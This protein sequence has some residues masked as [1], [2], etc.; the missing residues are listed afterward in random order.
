MIDGPRHTSGSCSPA[1]LRTASMHRPPLRILQS[2]PGSRTDTAAQPSSYPRPASGWRSVGTTLRSSRRTPIARAFSTFR[3]GV[4]SIGPERPRRSIRSR[5]RGGTSHPGR[6]SWTFCVAY[7]RS[8][9]STFTL[10]TASMAWRSGGGPGSGGSLHH[11]GARQPR[12]VD[13]HQKQRAKDLYH[14]FIEDPIIHGASAMLCTSRREELSFRDLGYTVPTWVIPIGID[15]DA[16][17]CARSPPLRRCDR[18]WCRCPRH[19]FL[20]RISAKKG[21]LLLVESFRSIAAAFPRAHLVIAGPDDEGIGRGLVSMI[22]NAGLA[23]RVPSL[24]LWADLRSGRSFSDPMSLCSH[25][26]TRASVSQLRRP[27]PSGVPS[28]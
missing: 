19:H 15:A 1:G 26:P 22:A 24:E 16:V 7:Q 12:P 9:S 14:A 21:V 5:C 11:S 20:G 13:R 28:W 8:T 10:F 2:S 18:H 3:P 6:C 4:S 25:R 27:W 17:T 23:D